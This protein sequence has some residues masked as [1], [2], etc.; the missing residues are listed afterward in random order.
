[1][2]LSPQELTAPSEG[3]LP[4]TVATQERRQKCGPKKGAVNMRTVVESLATSPH[5]VAALPQR[6]RKSYR[7]LCT[8]FLS[9]IGVNT[10]AGGGVTSTAASHHGMQ[11]GAARSPPPSSLHSHHPATVLQQGQRKSYRCPCTNWLS[12]PYQEA[13]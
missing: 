11:Y 10:Q 5:S 7:C 13:A 9:I 8:N 1:L 6:Q 12:I 2:Q 3:G 4:S